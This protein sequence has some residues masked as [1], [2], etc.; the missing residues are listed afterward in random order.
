MGLEDRDWFKER[1]IDWDKGG[2]KPAPKRSLWEEAYELS[3]LFNTKWYEI[4]KINWW[5]EFY[6]FLKLRWWIRI[7]LAV[8][9]AII[10]VVVYFLI[11]R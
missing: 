8:C 6:T 4:Y 7:L 3:L 9:F 11:V 10:A 2:L 1:K 5:K